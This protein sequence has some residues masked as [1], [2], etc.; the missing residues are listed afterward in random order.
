MPHP[1]DAPH[2]RS[3]RTAESASIAPTADDNG[4]VRPVDVV[5]LCPAGFEAVV[6]GAARHDLP[7][8]VEERRSSGFIRARTVA[9]VRQLRE[10][11][12]AT[13][14]FAVIDEAPRSTVDYEL[15]ALARRLRQLDRPPGLPR[16]GTLRL[17]VHDDGRFTATDAGIAAEMERALARWSGLQVSRRG[18]SLEV[19]LLRRRDEPNTTL[20]TK[21]SEGA[22]QPARGV[23]RP[24]IC[25]A[26]ARVE[27][28]RGARLVVD[29]F[30]GSGAIGEACLEAGAES[31]WLNDIE[32]SQGSRDPI[33]WT[34]D[35]FAALAVPPRS[36][37]AIVTDPPWG[38]FSEIEEGVE[39]LY[40]RVGSA[41][42]EWLRPGGA[43]VVLTG[44]P[45]SSVQAL[46]EAGELALERDHPVLVNGRKARVIRAR[47]PV[48]GAM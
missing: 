12:C 18:G 21:L 11:P 34:H 47:K 4:C 22:R 40:A 45:E 30:A 27:P 10:F 44:A 39:R 1:N 42:A 32:G 23:L 29:P 19:W 48:T 41:A 37:D 17:R 16:R 35:D 5:I 20:A 33:R 25:A 43:I 3:V 8:F 46:L 7:K 14:A 26:L 6:A 31:V 2:R 36:V 13:N 24:E 9:P 15:R 38:H 28:L